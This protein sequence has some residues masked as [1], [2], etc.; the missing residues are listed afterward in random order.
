MDNI[1]GLAFCHKTKGLA[2]YQPTCLRIYSHALHIAYMP[3]SLLLLVLLML[4][5]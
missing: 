1:N 2:N 5:G 3:I 4:G